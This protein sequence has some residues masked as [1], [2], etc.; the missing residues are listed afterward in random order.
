MLD[1]K[2]V[3]AEVNKWAKAEKAKGRKDEKPISNPYPAYKPT[4]KKK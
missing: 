4:K 2:K 1:K 3:Q